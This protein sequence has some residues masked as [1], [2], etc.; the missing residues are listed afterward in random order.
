MKL[1]VKNLIVKIG[2]KQHQLMD[3]NVSVDDMRFAE[4]KFY[5]KAELRVQWVPRLSIDEI[6]DFLDSYTGISSLSVIMDECKKESSIHEK[7]QDIFNGVYRMKIKYEVVDNN[8]VLD[9]IGKNLIKG[10]NAL[11]SLAGHPPKCLYCKE[12]GHLRSEC[13]KIKEFCQKCRR[14]GHLADKCTLATRITSQQ[15]HEDESSDMEE[16][17]DPN[18]LLETVNT[19]VSTQ[20]TVETPTVDPT[21][22]PTLVLTTEPTLVLTAE[23]TVVHAVVPTVVS[24]VVPTVE[25]KLPPTDSQALKVKQ[26]NLRKQRSLSNTRNSGARSKSTTKN[27][28]KATKEAKEKLMQDLKE[29]QQADEFAASN[30]AASDAIKQAN[31]S[32]KAKAAAKLAANSSSST[33]PASNRGKR[34]NSERSPDEADDEATRD[35]KTLLLE[36]S[37]NASSS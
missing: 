33:T 31:A 1:K 32:V 35:S 2:E 5:I 34:Y 4:R 24:T 28:K 36:N 16:E 13:R 25:Q 23:P 20:E 30:S 27:E 17:M 7:G 15:S 37:S 21:V 8:K 12:F 3:A 29:K 19:N 26:E 18:V 14:L 11:I 22:E 6:A 9:L 10:Q